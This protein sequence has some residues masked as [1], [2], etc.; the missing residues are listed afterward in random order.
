MHIF[1]SFNGATPLE[2]LFSMV[3]LHIFKLQNCAC[4]SEYLLANGAA[5]PFLTSQWCGSSRD[6]HF[7]GV[8]APFHALKISFP[9]MRIHIFLTLNGTTPPEILLSMVQL[10]L[11]M[12]QNGA[13][14]SEDILPNGV[15]AH[16]LAFQW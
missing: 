12:L 7:N 6:P 8:A 9:M 14:S 11:L 16:F 13:R 3:R 15:V 4:S 5:A 10:H 2:I 1:L